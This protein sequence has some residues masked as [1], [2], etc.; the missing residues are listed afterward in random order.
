MVKISVDLP[1]EVADRLNDLAGTVKASP[2][3][4]LLQ[5]ARA[6]L[7][8]RDDLMRSIA[9]GLADGEAGRT[10]PHEE[11]MAEMEAWAEGLKAR[12]RRGT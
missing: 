3:A 7:D 5:A 4:L 11:V 8:D 1:D 2:E 10:V 6:M 9:R 12:H